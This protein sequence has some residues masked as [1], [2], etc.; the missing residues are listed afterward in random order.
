MLSSRDR[1][2]TS[3]KIQAVKEPE[4]STDDRQLRLLVVA[5]GCLVGLCSLMLQARKGSFDGSC[6]HR[7]TQRLLKRT[8]R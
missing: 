7:R 6:G 5:A 1:D 8:T 4:I 3:L 2:F